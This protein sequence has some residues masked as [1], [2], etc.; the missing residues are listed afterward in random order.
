MA[1]VDLGR[2]IVPSVCP[3]RDDGE[4]DEAGLRQHL[5]YLASV[6]GIG[7]VAFNLYAGEVHSL[8]REERLRVLDIGVREL[9][10][11]VPV[12]CGVQPIPDTTREA[13]AFAKEAAARGADALLLMG[14]AWFAFGANT[15][16]GVAVSYAHAVLDAVDRPFMIFQLPKWTGAHY[17]LDNLRAICAKPNV[18]GV[19]IVTW[20][21]DEFEATARMLHALPHRPRAYTGNDTTFL[22]NFLGGADGTL[23]GYNNVALEIVIAMYDAVQ[24]GDL[25]AAMA[26]QRRQEPLVRVL[27]AE[28]PMLYRSR[29][30]YAAAHL[31]RFQGPRMRAPLPDVDDRDAEVIHRALATANLLIPVPA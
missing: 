24:S 7:A 15:V 21:T 19:K 14:P 31:G 4:I 9:D 22:Y 6:Q 17:T 3:F 20:D 28:P 18:V 29:Y 27:F 16:P 11:K 30:K 5:R 2:H 13:I 26:L 1:R 10:G 8:S 12:I 23:L 25:S